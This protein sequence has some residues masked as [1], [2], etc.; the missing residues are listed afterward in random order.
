MSV[1]EGLSGGAGRLRMLAAIAALLCFLVGGRE[2]A[3]VVNAHGARASDDGCS[4][5]A[6]LLLFALLCLIADSPSRSVSHVPSERSCV[7]LIDRG[8]HVGETKE[9]RSHA[10]AGAASRACSG[11]IRRDARI[12]G[13]AGTG[14]PPVVTGPGDVSR[15][16]RSPCPRGLPFRNGQRLLRRV[17]RHAQAEMN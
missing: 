3:R 2:L 16:V 17:A 4:D 7:G 11:G 5:I 1:A 8:V 12:A 9:R 14:L 6:P 10:A 15:A 13:D